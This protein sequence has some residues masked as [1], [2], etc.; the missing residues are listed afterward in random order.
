MRPVSSD[1]IG[2]RCPQRENFNGGHF[3][4]LLEKHFML[5]INT[6]ERFFCGPTYF[7]R[8][9]LCSRA[10]VVHI[11]APQAIQLQVRD[12]RVFRSWDRNGN[13]WQLQVIGT[14]YLLE[15]NSTLPFSFV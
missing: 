11:S 4:F 1:A 6:D 12:A 8:P 2:P 7:G 9:P 15:W 5:A 14:I 3:R 13:S 10:R